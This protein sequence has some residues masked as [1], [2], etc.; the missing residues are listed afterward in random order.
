MA[1]KGDVINGFKFEEFLGGGSFGTV[2]KATKAGKE[3]A[4]KSITGNEKSADLEESFT[5][6]KKLIN[7]FL[8][9]YHKSFRKT[10]KSPTLF[11]CMEF[12]RGGD[13]AKLVNGFNEKKGAA[14]FLLK[15][16]KKIIVECLLGLYEL[17]SNKVIHRDIKLENIFVDGEYNIKIGDFGCGIILESTLGQAKTQAGTLQYMSPEI[18]QNIPYGYE[19]DVWSMGVVFYALCTLRMPFPPNASAFMKI[20]N[21][22]YEP[23]NDENYPE[24]VSK[25]VHA[26][27]EKVPTK[28]PSVEDLLSRPEVQKWATQVE[29]FA[30]EKLISM[31]PPDLVKSS[32]SSKTSSTTSATPKVNPKPTLAATPT[33]SPAPPPASVPKAAPA[34]RLKTGAHTEGQTIVIDTGSYMIRAGIGGEDAPRAVLP[35]LIGRPKSSVTTGEEYIGLEAFLKR[36]SLAINYPLKN[37]TINLDEL[38]KIYNYTFSEELGVRPSDHPVLLTGRATAPR[39]A[40]ER[41]T[42]LFFE[43]FAVPA[44]YIERQAQLTLWVSGRQTGVVVDVG[45]Y[46]TDVVPMN[47][48]RSLGAFYVPMPLN[49]GGRAVTQSL[50][51]LLHERGYGKYR[52]DLYHEDVRE[53]KEK[54]GY[55]AV[56]FIGEMK[57]ADTSKKLDQTFTMPD[58]KQLT[59][60]SERFRCAE[61]FF[62]EE[63]NHLGK[64]VDET[65]MKCKGGIRDVLYQ[66]VYLVGGTA[67][68]NGFAERLQRELARKEVKVT[69]PPEC[70]YSVW[71][72]GSICASLSSF[73]SQLITKA[74]YKE[75]GAGIVHRKCV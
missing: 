12:C 63:E 26:M 50:Q 70:K 66:N 40:R 61:V 6:S 22:E 54:L 30:G 33:P 20:L 60:G 67:R 32:T 10:E 3:Y 74:E 45:E 55:V 38:E 46:E 16:L 72:G 48:G 52:S 42:T 14:G 56:D 25:L 75:F 21:C 27:L 28:R 2:W 18:F 62:K 17:H 19:A 11:V 64:L 1:E 43:K 7:P 36:E 9:Q 65:I 37:S 44:F 73:A 23:I 57:T 15:H 47:E 24:E 5:T 49:V 39:V 31:F 58:G 13:L 69:A 71:I 35:T 59:I 34:T 51:N 53:L 4:I 8:V 29:Y 41:L 68:L